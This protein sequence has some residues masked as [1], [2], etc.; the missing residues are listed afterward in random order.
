MQKVN[1]FISSTFIDLEHYRTEVDITIRVLDSES[2]CM[3]HF[4][5]DNREPV[6]VCLTAI[7]ECD[8]FVGIYGLRYGFIPPSQTLS[9]TELEYN[10]ARSQGKPILAFISRDIIQYEKDYVSEAVSIDSAEVLKLKSFKDRIRLERVIR[11]F[12]TKDELGKYMAIELGKHYIKIIRGQTLS[13]PLTHL[14]LPNDIFYPTDS[15]YVGLRYFS[16]KEAKVFYGRNQLIFDLYQKLHRPEP[17]ILVY[18]Q[19]GVGKSSVLDAG[20]LPRLEKQNWLIF[21]LKRLYEQGLP[22]QLKIILQELKKID[23]NHLLVIDQVEELWT[24][25]NPLL[26]IEK[27]DFFK[28]INS[29]LETYD[30]NFKIILSFRKEFLAEVR[31]ALTDKSYSQQMVKPMNQP[32]LIEA[33]TQIQHDKEALKRYHIKVSEELP[34]EI[35]YDLRKDEKSHLAPLLQATLSQM[36]ELANKT[37]FEDDISFDHKLY[38]QVKTESLEE[39]LK[40]QLNKMVRPF[41]NFLKTGCY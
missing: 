5:I 40:V 16:R 30:K 1:V 13:N 38:N 35:A 27:E 21:P 11:E 22:N 23:E 6:E 4:G 24:N 17:I 36:W 8:L 10:Y 15:P 14:P 29:L 7:D 19:T 26:K 37:G 31:D 9:I 18:G 20:L 32:E 33:I 28:I 12:V 2:I 41:Q 39:F 34:H 25:P 3:E